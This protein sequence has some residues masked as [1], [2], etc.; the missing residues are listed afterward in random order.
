MGVQI[1]DG[2]LRVFI[3]GGVHGT[4]VTDTIVSVGGFFK[5]GIVCGT[6]Q[7]RSDL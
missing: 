3:T 5:I 7:I 1:V 2:A 6:G 4:A